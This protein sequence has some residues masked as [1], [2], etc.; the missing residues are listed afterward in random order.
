MR[1]NK[2]ELPTTAADILRS[3][4]ENE[5]KRVFREYGELHNASH[6]SNVI[7][8]NRSSLHMVTV[9]EFKNLIAVCADKRKENQF[10]AK[11]FQALRIE[12]NDEL[13]SLKKLLVQSKD[14]LKEGGRMVVISY[15]SL[16]DRL[17]KN[18]FRSGKFEGD[19]EKDIYGK[20]LAPF[21]VIT[22]QPLVPT[23]I[24]IE[25]NPRARS[26]KLRVAERVMN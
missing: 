17:V 24:E 23:E 20:S 3:Y 1:M 15:H 18:F 6:L 12:V 25:Q 4:S 10:Y 7:V 19:A 2:N 5:L 14:M 26:A 16:E 11:V 22:R 9:N 13:N 8:K 21:K